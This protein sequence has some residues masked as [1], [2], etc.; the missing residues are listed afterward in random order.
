MALTASWAMA[1][2]IFSMAA[3]AMTTF[4]VVTATT[5]WM[6]VMAMTRLMAAMAMTA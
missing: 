1:L 5:H 3:L 2:P 4:S 6:A